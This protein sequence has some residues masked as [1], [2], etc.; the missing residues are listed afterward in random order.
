MRRCGTRSVR[1]RPAG[2]TGLMREAIQLLPTLWQDLT[3][4]R[5]WSRTDSAMALLGPEGFAEAVLAPAD[6]VGEVGRGRLG[7]TS[8]SVD[9]PEP[10]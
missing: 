1:T 5:R 7:P 4:V 2:A 3:A 9:S 10:Q 6:G 8:R